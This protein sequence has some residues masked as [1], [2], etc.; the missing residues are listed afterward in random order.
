M[1]HGSANSNARSAGVKCGPGTQGSWVLIKGRK[2]EELFIHWSL[3]WGEDTGRQ[4]LCR[5]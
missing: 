2:K 5:G 3:V 1:S 4:V